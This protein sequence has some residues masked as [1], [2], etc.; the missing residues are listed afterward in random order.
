MKGKWKGYKSIVLLSMKS[1]NKVFFLVFCIKLNLKEKV[2]KF[3]EH[4]LN[5]PRLPE[6]YF[7]WEPKTDIEVR[8]CPR[9]LLKMCQGA[10]PIDKTPSKKADSTLLG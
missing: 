4:E 5:T 6:T 2:V 1:S 3:L 9:I 7:I 10:F 8:W